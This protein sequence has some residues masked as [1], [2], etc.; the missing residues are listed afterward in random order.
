MM[1]N[2]LRALPFS[3]GAYNALKTPSLNNLVLH[4]TWLCAPSIESG[5]KQCRLHTCCHSCPGRF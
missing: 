1:V 5:R 4:A 2:V 3:L